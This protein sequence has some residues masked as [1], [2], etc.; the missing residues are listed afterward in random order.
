MSRDYVFTSWTQPKYDESK[1]KY[2]CWGLE[3]CPT[4]DREHHQGF[5]IFNRTH[6]IPSAKRILG[7]G[8]ECHLEPRRG[9]R[10]QARDYCRKD[11]EFFEWGEF[12]AMTKE[13]LFKKS[14]KWLL[15]NG[16]EEFFC[17]YHKAI[18]EKQDKG[19]AWREVEVTY[20]W[21]EPGTG[22]T[23]KV[24]EMEDVYKWDSP[25]QWFDGYDG[26]NILLIDDYET[27]EIPPRVL[28]NILD[29]YRYKLNI[30]GGHT[31]AK[32]SKIYITSNYDIKKM[33]EWHIKGI[34][35]RIHNI[36]TM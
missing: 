34:Q 28:K 13:Q 2:I 5:A 8:D 19:E 30:K 16:Y 24:M 32:W 6:R 20:I 12:D 36:V 22:K 35:R 17:R 4:T 7:G 15:D 23:R 33:D 31:Y 25:Y 27:G 1:L 3:R 21:G 9:T 18:C 29:G 10:Q 26:E 11:G 14:K